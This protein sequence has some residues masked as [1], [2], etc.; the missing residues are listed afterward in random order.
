MD[1]VRLDLDAT[2][3]SATKGTLKPAESLDRSAPVIGRDAAHPGSEGVRRA[4]TSGAFELK[5]VETERDAS[6]P[7]LEKGASYHPDVRPE[8]LAE[9]RSLELALK[10]TKANDRSEPLVEK[11]IH[12]DTS[13]KPPRTSVVD[14]LKQKKPVIDALSTLNEHNA[15]EHI[16]KFTRPELLTE[17]KAKKADIEELNKHVV[18]NSKSELQKN[19]HT[20]GRA[21]RT[22]SHSSDAGD[23]PPQQLVQCAR[24]L[25]A[26]RRRDQAEA[27]IYPRFCQLRGE[28]A[29]RQLSRADAPG[30][31][32]RDPHQARLHRGP[33]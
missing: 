16:E 12:I 11:W 10:P 28:P 9:L 2:E 30:A 13:S 33:H 19:V 31:G 17:L 29:A 22:H 14:E 1:G 23:S 5:H 25:V 18:Q 4:I 15:K 20:N 8:V 3:L 6:M 26:I 21:A 24:R 27:P 7:V 32:Q